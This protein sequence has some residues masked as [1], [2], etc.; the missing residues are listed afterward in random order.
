M[1]K[2]SHTILFSISH[3]K[4]TVIIIHILR[5]P[6]LTKYFIKFSCKADTVRHWMTEIPEKKKKEKK[7]VD[8]KHSNTKH[9]P[10]SEVKLQSSCPN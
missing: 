4:I 8:C 5:R 9:Q 6:K 10:T 3:I 2:Y 1:S 7:P